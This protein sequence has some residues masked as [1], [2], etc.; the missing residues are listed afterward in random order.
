MDRRWEKG[1]VPKP[2]WGAFTRRNQCRGK[3]KWEMCD[4]EVR[5]LVA[6]G[7]FIH[8]LTHPSIHPSFPPSMPPSIHP[9]IHL[10]IYSSMS[11]SIPPPPSIHL[12]IHPSIHPPIYSS[13]H[14][15]IHPSLPPSLPPSIH[16]YIYP[17]TYQCIHPSLPSSVHPCIH[18]SIYPSIYS[19][20]HP[21]VHPSI[22]FHPPILSFTHWIEYT[23]SCDCCNNLAQS[24]WFKTMHLYH[25]IVMELRHL[26]GLSGLKSRVQEGFVP[27]GGSRGEPVSLPFLLLEAPSPS[28]SSQTEFSHLCLF[29]FFPSLHFPSGVS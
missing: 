27:S 15:S 8:L 12:C 22:C 2:N 11:P 9:S 25:L 16:T 10:P 5:S 24:L 19:S 3:E 14:P 18:L 13:I 29:G 21:S 28:S 23:V 6:A 4:I 26:T 1:D 20:T 17:S 7:T